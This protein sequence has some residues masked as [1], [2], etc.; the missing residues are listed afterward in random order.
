MALTDFFKVSASLDE[1]LILSED[2][3]IFFPVFLIRTE[4]YAFLDLSTDFLPL[5]TTF[6][7]LIEVSHALL[8]VTAKHIFF[9]N[10]A[11]ASLINLVA[12]L[13]QQSLHSFRASIV[14]T[15]LPNDSHAGQNV[16][17]KAWDFG[18]LSFL[19]LTA[20]LFENFKELKIV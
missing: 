7:A 5:A 11:S 10:L 8:D 18:R 6:N 3:V 17:D 1:G 15:K 20:G 14:L 9:I 2:S 12:D 13:G 19:N 4:N 16:W